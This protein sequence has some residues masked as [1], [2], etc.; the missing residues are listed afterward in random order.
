MIGVNASIS[1]SEWYPIARHENKVKTYE[2]CVMYTDAYNHWKGTQKCLYGWQYRAPDN[3]HNVV[4]EYDLVCERKYL[5]NALFYLSQVA[6]ILG[7]IVWAMIGDRCE[8]RNTVL[9]TLYLFVSSSVSLHFVTDFLQ[10]SILY[11]LESFFAAVI[12][13]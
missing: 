6:A 4:I 10:F 3:E 5:L 9:I 13:F 7:A 11:S 12:V 2:S 8:R 1:E